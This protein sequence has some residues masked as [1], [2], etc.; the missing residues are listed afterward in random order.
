MRIEPDACPNV[1]IL[2][3]FG[4]RYLAESSQYLLEHLVKNV[5]AGKKSWRSGLP[6]AKVQSDFVLPLSQIVFPIAC[7]SPDGLHRAE[8]PSV[9][10]PKKRSKNCRRQWR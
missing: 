5:L 7:S 4:R 1:H 9:R 3:L 8:E 6:A 10:W 2:G